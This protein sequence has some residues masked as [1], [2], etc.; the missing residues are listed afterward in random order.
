MRDLFCLRLPVFLLL[1]YPLD[2]IY[3]PSECPLKLKRPF[4]L[5]NSIYLEGVRGPC[6]SDDR[7][8]LFPYD[9]TG[10]LLDVC[11]CP[12]PEISVPLLFLPLLV[13]L[14]GR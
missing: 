3:V 5:R 7:G 6:A 11:Q 9:L 10:S 8:N 14:P 12:Y 2:K 4:P 13:K 1:I